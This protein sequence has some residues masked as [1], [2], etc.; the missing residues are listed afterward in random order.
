VNFAPHD[1]CQFG[2]ECSDRYKEHKKHPVFSHDE[3]IITTALRDTSAVTARWLQHEMKDLM[4]RESNQR[5]KVMAALPD[6][7]VVLEEVDR[8]EE[9]VQCAHCNAYIYL[10]QVGCSCGPKVVCHDHISEVTKKLAT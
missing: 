4:K 10:S 3:L 7:R 8:P 9:E 1:W 2:V 6:I 5:K